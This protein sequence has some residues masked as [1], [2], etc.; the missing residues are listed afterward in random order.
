MSHYEKPVVQQ[1]WNVGGVLEIRE[2]EK[3]DWNG[4]WG[5]LMKGNMDHNSEWAFIF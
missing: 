4:K 1:S 3:L 5:Q 2:C